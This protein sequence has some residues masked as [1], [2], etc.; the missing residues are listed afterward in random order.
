M[1]SATDHLSRSIPSQQEFVFLDQLLIEP[2]C[3]SSCTCWNGAAL[4]GG[5]TCTGPGTHHDN[6]VVQILH[7][8]SSVVG[9][10]RGRVGW[11]HRKPRRVHPPVFAEEFSFLH[12]DW[13]IL[14][15][16]PDGSQATRYSGPSKH[17]RSALV[18]QHRHH[19]VLPNFCF[20]IIQMS[21]PCLLR[22]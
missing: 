7:V 8:T 20:F 17:V 1:R 13:H 18:Q 4:A 10:F 9:S 15:M 14:L 21:S 12:L 3:I 6:K 11:K 19:P 22:G 2:I 16:S 5:M